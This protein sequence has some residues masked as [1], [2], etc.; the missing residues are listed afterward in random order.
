MKTFSRFSTAVRS[1]VVGLLAAI[2][3]SGGFAHAQAP[4]SIL[5]LSLN[6]PTFSAGDTLILT[7]INE[8][9]VS[10]AGDLYLAAQLPDGSA[11]AFDGTN[12]L[13]I[14]DG[15]NFIPG[16]L[17]PFRANTTISASSEPLLTIQLTSPI[18]AGPYTAFAFL[19]KGGG[20]PLD[21]SNWQSNLA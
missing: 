11:Y 4:S 2:L 20:D 5:A 17:K 12:W 1:G 9:G 21:T 8:N 3:W 13:L 19:V 10:A 18:P 6:K 15:T 16:A 7:L 14:F